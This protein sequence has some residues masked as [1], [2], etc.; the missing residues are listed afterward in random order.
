MEASQVLKDEG[1]AN[2]VLHFTEI[3]P[4][5]AEPVTAALKA[6]EKNVV[7][8]NNATGQLASLVREETGIQAGYRINKY[9]GRPVSARYI[10]DE[11]KKG[12]I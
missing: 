6:T 3:W 11:L 7:I 9:D 10:V 2:N 12:V 8:E 5:P 4:F 1:V